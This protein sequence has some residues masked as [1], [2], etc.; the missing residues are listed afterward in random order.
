MTIKEIFKKV[1]DEV[2]EELTK[3][4]RI[5]VATKQT[6]GR[7]ACMCIEKYGIKK[8]DL[9]LYYQL[10]EDDIY[11][12][13]KDYISPKN[14]D[15]G[16]F[17]GFEHAVNFT[18]FAMESQKKIKQ[19]ED[20]CTKDFPGSFNHVVK[21]NHE[22]RALKNF[23]DAIESCKI[24][25]INGKY[26]TNNELLFI[27]LASYICTKQMKMPMKAIS[28]FLKKDRS[29]I[30][31]YNNLA[32]KFILG[33]EKNAAYIYQKVIEDLCFFEEDFFQKTIAVLNQFAMKKFEKEATILIDHFTKMQANSNA[34]E[35]SL[36]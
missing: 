20:F 7:V 30:Y 11:K 34:N 33:N 31:H 19:V 27:S 9:A 22:K 32:K 10:T 15:K 28:F 13:Y 8:R 25:R 14:K 18:F 1:Y 16:N 17:Y 23:D 2:K 12:I 3:E 6:I 36:C 24:G 26:T 21:M 4:K 35:I 5:N 29:S